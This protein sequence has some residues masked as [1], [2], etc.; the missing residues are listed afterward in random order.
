MTTDD[1]SKST[2][3]SHATDASADGLRLTLGGGVRGEPAQSAVEGAAPS[4]GG[5]H[6]VMPS[7]S[8]TPPRPA[9]TDADV[10]AGVRS[11]FSANSSQPAV[12]GAKSTATPGAF[13]APNASSGAPLRMA[14]R[15]YGANEVPTHDGVPLGR[16]GTATAGRPLPPTGIFHKPVPQ[17]PGPRAGDGSDHASHPAAESP[18]NEPSATVGPDGYPGVE[19]EDDEEIPLSLRLRAWF[20]G[21]DWNAKLL[22]GVALALVLVAVLAIWSV[23]GCGGDGGEFPEDP[24]ALGDT[25]FPGDDSGFP[26]DDV[27]SQ[28]SA[29]T[30][31]ADAIP[32]A[33]VSPTQAT[34][35][36]S[37]APETPGL[38]A[39]TISGFQ[40]KTLDNG[41]FLV[42]DEPAFTSVDYIS[43]PG[44]AALKLLSAKLHGLA[45]G[46]KVTVT[47]F[48][49]NIPMSHPTEKF[50]SN[51]DIA[52][53]RAIVA[54][55]HLR[56][57]AKNDALE[58]ETLA[59]AETDAPYPNDTPANRR[60]NRTVTVKV[61]VR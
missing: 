14:P 2:F 45:G 7:S 21:R 20:A 51:A 55:D 46:A 39:W 3:G 18:S 27:A 4:G 24:V 13:S 6:L 60:L 15:G 31:P 47:G 8:S 61:V 44:M 38:P 35:V 59:G 25:P 56:A 30:Q 49:D 11:I 57:Y 10:V 52:R 5:A 40:I 34:A 58:F 9:E 43:K 23:R 16:E 53:A 1:E 33:A 41:Y 19:W 54:T 32:A 48:T 36:A 22:G 12:T 29:G 50:Q 26:A 37:A 17:E 42:F 28:P